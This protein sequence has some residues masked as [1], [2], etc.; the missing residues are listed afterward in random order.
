LKYHASL[1]E[2]GFVAIDPQNGHI[3]AWIGGKNMA[4]SQYDHVSQS[5]RQP[6]STFKPFVYAT[7]IE[8]GIADPCDKYSNQPITFTLSDGTKWKP[9]NADD[10]YS[11][12][13]TLTEALARSSNVIA[14]KL[15][16]LV[17][18][19]NVVDLAHRVGIQSQLTPTPALALGTSEVTLLELTTAYGTFA[20]KGVLISPSFISRI[21]DK[22]RNM[23]YQSEF[24]TT[25]VITPK[26][27]FTMVGMLRAVVDHPDGTAS[28]L[29]RTY[30]ITEQMA[31][32]TGTSQEN[33]DGWFIGMTP[34]Q[35]VGVWVGWADRRIH[36]DKDDYRYGAGNR[37]ALR[38]AALYFQKLFNDSQIGFPS[39]VFFVPPEMGSELVC[40]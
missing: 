35:V 8:K 40:P 32:K 21:E 16:D 33:A 18:P 31:A 19:Q 30:G 12:D 14:C 36:F 27:A 5:R 1:A 4:I 10:T 15:M 7:A 38:V 26:T 11:G 37:T 17:R 6:G 24:Q 20:N 13:M 34:H 29:R 23:L 28:E 39:T 3:K 22:N 2:V 25:S 9:R